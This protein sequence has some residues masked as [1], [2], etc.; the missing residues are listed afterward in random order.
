MNTAEL[1]SGVLYGFVVV[2][3]RQ[4]DTNFAGLTAEQRA[5]IVRWLVKAIATAEP[6]AKRGSTAPWHETHE[7]VVDLTD[8]QPVSGV[9]AFEEPCAPTSA[10]ALAALHAH[11]A[12]LDRRL[13][14]PLV[15]VSL[16]GIEAAKAP[17]GQPALDVLG[18][19]VAA[20][21]RQP[22]QAGPPD[23]SLGAA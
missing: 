13:G 8:R 9:G 5:G 16:T 21:V 4:L 22:L 1:V 2:D 14:V 3:L 10:A 18:D 17:T 15:R 6:A 23:A 11:L 12:R 7:V 19:R 20:A